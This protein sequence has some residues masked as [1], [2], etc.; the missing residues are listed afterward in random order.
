MTKL[1]DVERIHLEQSN[2]FLAHSLAAQGKIFHLCDKHQQ[3]CRLL[4]VKKDNEN[5]GRVFF[6]CRYN[7]PLSCNYFHW[8]DHQYVDIS[9]K[10]YTLIEPQQLMQDQ[11]DEE[12]EENNL[13]GN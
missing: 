7:K 12:V 8:A 2:P 9:T 3:V 1:T 10:P 11:D 4:T 6:S 5:K 13:K